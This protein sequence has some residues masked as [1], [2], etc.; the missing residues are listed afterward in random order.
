MRLRRLFQRLR[1]P[2]GGLLLLEAGARAALP[3]LDVQALANFFRSSGNILLSLYDTI[4]GGALARGGVLALGILPWF[5]ALIMMRLARVVSPR[6]EAI[7]ESADGER[8][9]RRWTRILTV[10][11]ALIQS[12][13]FAQFAQ[14]VQG[15]VTDPGIGFMLRTM[16]L[17]TMG[18]VFAMTVGEMIAH[19]P[20][21][22]DEVL[23]PPAP[24]ELAAP[25]YDSAGAREAPVTVE[26]ESPR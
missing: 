6:L 2:V 8:T 7:H 15:A 23:R 11:L 25:A 1:L 16:F 12:F 4:G 24:P 9:F 10:A 5:S 3:G 26:R 20:A 14:T 17:L 22:D 19:S 21:D 13:G 18:S